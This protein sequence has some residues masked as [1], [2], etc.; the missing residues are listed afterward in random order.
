MTSTEKIS[1]Y[2]ELGKKKTIACTLNYF[3]L[4]RIAKSED[5]ALASLLAY[6][7][8]Y[9]EILNTA[10]IDFQA[11]SSLDDLNIIAR[12]EGNAT[13]DFGSPGIIPDEDKRN[14]S[15]TDQERYEK[16]LRVC[17]KAFDKTVINAKGKELRK[18]PRGGGRGLEKIIQHVR[19][20][21]LAYLR[22]QAQTVPK[23][24]RED[25]HVIH[26]AILETLHA[27]VRGEIPEKGP[28]GGALW[29]T[30]Y[31]VRS[32]VGHV[33]DHIWEIEDRVLK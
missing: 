23:E 16:L 17:W 10:G 3:G 30:P 9:S 1:I 13:T 14:I 29:P 22:K 20:S 21:N 33:V 26:L 27:A 19:E 2:L 11:P 24:L 6:S 5:E 31:F 28:R 7:K 18:G 15:E 8:R 32:T 12:Y 25:M 4:F